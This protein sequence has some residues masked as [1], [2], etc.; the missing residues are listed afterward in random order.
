MR[1]K[2][3]LGGYTYYHNSAAW[4]GDEIVTVPDQ[5]ADEQHHH[6]RAQTFYPVPR[7]GGGTINVRLHGDA[8]GLWTPGTGDMIVRKAS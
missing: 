7:G 8:Y 1:A 2:K 4:L 5:I 3:E 6:D